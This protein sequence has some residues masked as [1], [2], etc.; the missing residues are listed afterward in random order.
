LLNTPT[1]SGDYKQERWG[2]H[3][4]RLDAVLLAT[5]NMPA[6]DEPLPHCDFDRALGGEWN[7]HRAWAR[8]DDRLDQRRAFFET[9]AA[10]LPQNE[11]IPLMPSKDYL[12][13]RSA[14]KARLEARSDADATPAGAPRP[15]LAQPSP[16]LPHPAGSHSDL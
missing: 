2:R 12:M 3:S 7:D 8:I 5:V 10:Q 9:A 15:I 11:E 14:Q 13:L 4:K 16:R 6:K 1:A